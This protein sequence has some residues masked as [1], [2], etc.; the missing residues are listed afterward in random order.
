M[1]NALTPLTTAL[2]VRIPRG[3][4]VAPFPVEELTTLTRLLVV[5][6]IEED[7]TGA[8]LH[9]HQGGRGRLTL[10]DA[11]YATFLQL[12]RRSQERQHPVGVRF[13]EGHVITKVVRAD[14]DIPKECWEESSG[15]TRM[16]FQGHEGVFYF[17]PDHPESARV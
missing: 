6:E 3:Q 15:R 5:R 9:F 8:T 7:E 11:S 1:T 4:Q 2:N 10:G 12:A 14:N 13:G 16:L 17:K